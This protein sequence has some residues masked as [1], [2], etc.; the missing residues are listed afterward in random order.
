[1]LL[2]AVQLEANLTAFNVCGSD[3]SCTLVLTAKVI[4][5]IVVGNGTC[6]TIVITVC[7]VSV[8]VNNYQLCVVTNQTGTLAVRPVKVTVVIDDQT[9]GNVT[10]V[11][12]C[13][14][15]NTTEP[16]RTNG[17]DSNLGNAVLDK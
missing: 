3:N 14:C 12:V 5:N 8:K 13:P 11:C 4:Y 9:V 1:M 17:I 15:S 2:V 10:T 7:I 6:G 16:A